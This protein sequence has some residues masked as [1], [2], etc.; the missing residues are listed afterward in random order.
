MKNR[1]Q[2]R[3]NDTLWATREDA[4]NYIDKYFSTD[5]YNGGLG[6]PS[7]KSEPLVLFY[8]PTPKESNV[9]LAIGREGDGNDKFSNASYFIIDFAEHTYEIGDI[10]GYIKDLE[11]SL[12]DITNT[13]ENNLQELIDL[14]SNS[15]NEEKERAT[16][17]EEELLK[18]INL[19]IVRAQEIESSLSE[20]I[21][22]EEQK[23]GELQELII[24]EINDRIKGDN[25]LEVKITETDEL[26]TNKIDNE[27][28][29]LTDNIQKTNTELNSYIKDVEVKLNNEIKRSEEADDRVNANF[30]K[31][32]SIE[33]KHSEDITRLD[34]EVK[35]LQNVVKQNKVNSSD[36]TININATENGTDITVNID[37]DTITNNNGKLCVN[38]NAFVKYEGNN[39][40]E[41]TPKDDSNKTISLK[42]NDKDN[43]L[44][45]D[46]NGLATNLRLSLNKQDLILFGN[47]DKVISRVDVSDLIAD[48]MIEKVEVVDNKIVFTFNT[49]G[50]GGEISIPFQD[51]FSLYTAD[52]GINIK[53]S[54]ISIKKSE[55]DE[56]FL[57]LDGSGLYIKGINQAIADK[58]ELLSKD[59]E[60][61]LDAI[62][63]LEENILKLESDLRKEYE[64]ADTSVKSELNKEITTTKELL[65]EQINSKVLEEQRRAELKESDLSNQID[66]NRT[67][68]ET[69]QGDVKKD[70]SVKDVIF[71]SII[72][73]I[74][75]NIDVDSAINQSLITKVDKDGTPYFYVSNN[76]D[77]M[78]YKNNSLTNVIDDLKLEDSNININV[79]NIQGDIKILQDSIN[80]LQTDVTKLIG[81]LSVLR[82]EF[83]NLSKNAITSIE[84]TSQE[85]KVIPTKDNSVQIGFAD[86]A[87]FIAG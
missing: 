44:T 73:Q 11:S 62:E 56:G 83:D 53:D 8:G 19:E 27:I 57:Q 47:N 82:S 4:V 9:I 6:N 68:I 67:N 14:I 69:L 87:E 41:V 65:Q 24:T 55:K 54:N 21:D 50:G 77:N 28:H 58:A 74:V 75:T 86:D 40:I 39:A 48:G 34:T 22:A 17:A 81:D 10:K 51:L 23:S 13:V 63:T 7:L 59:I 52:N 71:K 29:N 66:T 33:L 38:S 76:T 5:K 37:N 35:T 2:F 49:S 36:K 30:E 85:I 70:G 45:N 46:Y 3:Y 79:N 64:D 25:E 31:A 78:K 80:R 61:N 72:G 32:H 15:V 26:L 42:I 60:K 12:S 18:T 16:K 20:R 43:V 1:L 84:G